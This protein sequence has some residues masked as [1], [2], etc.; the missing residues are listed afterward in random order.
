MSNSVETRIRDRLDDKWLTPSQ[1][2]LWKAIQRFDGPPHRV[3][4]IY[5]TEGTG[6]TFMGWFLERINYS[7][8][9]IRPDM[10][11]PLLS[12]L[13]LDNALSD[14]AT[15]RELRPLVD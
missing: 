6:K 8:Y 5:G 10:S 4:N 11:K 15:T 2:V 13:T 14:R 1:N 3:I 12:R 7:A 9:S